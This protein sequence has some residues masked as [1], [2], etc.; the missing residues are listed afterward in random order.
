MQE[1]IEKKRS[2]LLKVILTALQT[3]FVAFLRVRQV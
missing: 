1:E 3:S 2:A